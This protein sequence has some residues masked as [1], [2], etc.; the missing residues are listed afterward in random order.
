LGVLLIVVGAVVVGVALLDASWNVGRR[1]MENQSWAESRCEGLVPPG[2]GDSKERESCLKREL[3]KSDLEAVQPQL[4]M[5][6]IGGIVIAAGVA[7][8]SSTR[9][10][11]RNRSMESVDGS[12]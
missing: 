3:G 9:R 7:V 12:V 4:H 1:Q 10:R 5:A 11:R 6:L 2:L 8:F